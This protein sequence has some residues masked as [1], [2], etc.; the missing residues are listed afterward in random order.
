MRQV[1]E[2]LV[3]NAYQAMPEGGTL[4]IE[5]KTVRDDVRL[6]IADTG[7]GIAKQDMAELFEPL[8]STKP[9][10]IGLGLA[11]TKTLVEANEGSI[12]VQ[13]QEGKGSTFTLILPV[14]DGED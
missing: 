5:A 6:S 3:T 12:E 9:R 11:V 1:L 4:T 7:M 2:N 10:G 13:S 8:F 14:A